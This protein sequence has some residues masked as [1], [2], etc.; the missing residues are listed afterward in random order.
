MLLGYHEF[1]LTPSA[2]IYCVTPEIFFGHLQV[3]KAAQACL[4]ASLHGC[5]DPSAEV[6]V[7]FDDA[8]I[9]QL[10][11]ALPLLER[12]GTVGHFFVPTGWVGHSTHTATWNDLRALVRLGHCVGS[13]SHRH[14]LL[15]QCSTPVLRDE[16][17]TSKML[18]ED[19]L[20]E[21]ID[22]ISM[23][24]GRYNRRVLAECEDAGYRRIF[25]SRPQP[26]MPRAHGDYGSTTVTGRLIVR[27]TLPL[28]TIAGYVRGERSTV[29]RL[30]LGY[31]CRRA[32][33]AA[34]GDVLYQAM[35][36]ALLRRMR[37]TQLA[38]QGT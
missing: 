27:R 37:D 16:L 31:S 32:V 25:S 7:T 23:P 15:T 12:T 30:Q 6:I 8:H 21:P 9:S 35:W 14:A 2:D 28:Q 33:K 13:H 17:I 36:R 20:G 4:P 18:L 26:D 10:R 22:S 1:A 38:E 3:A 34:A 19:R 11:H 5:G 29:Y 24:G